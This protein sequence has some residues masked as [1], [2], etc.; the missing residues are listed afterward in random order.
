MTKLQPIISPIAVE[1]L[2]KYRIAFLN[3]QKRLEKG[4]S[5]NS[6]FDNMR[7]Y[8]T[9]YQKLFSELQL[10]AFSDIERLIG[11]FPIT[12]NVKNRYLGLFRKANSPKFDSVQLQF[13]MKQS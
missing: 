10:T 7:Y 8:K 1:V 11:T 4:N 9:R 6:I 2:L 12:V 5:D 3:E 13:K